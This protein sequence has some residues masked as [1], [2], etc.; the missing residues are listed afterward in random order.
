MRVLIGLLILVVFLVLAFLTWYGSYT[1]DPDLT[2][3][4]GDLLKIA[5]G[6]IIG[7]GAAL[8]K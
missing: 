6:G 4:A 2:K 8:F 5:V 7:Y 3:L 1:S